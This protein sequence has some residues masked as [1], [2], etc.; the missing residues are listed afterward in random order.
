MSIKLYPELQCEHC[1]HKQQVFV[2]SVIS[3]RDP[4][5]EEHVRNMTVNVFDCKHCGY[6]SFIDTNIL[7]HND[8]LRY[9]IQYVCLSD[10]KDQGFYQQVT[11][12]GTAVLD[13]LDQK[14]IANNGQSY[15]FTPHYVFSIREMVAYIAFRDLCAAWG[16][17]GEC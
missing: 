6:Q 14:L 16:V 8:D 5:G 15:F 2:W 1:G 10:M 11:K 4:L 13:E 12:H 7:Y 3:S 17:E 9:C